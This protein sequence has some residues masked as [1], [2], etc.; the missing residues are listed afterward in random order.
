MY[1][2]T[3]THTHTHSHTH[4]R[5]GMVD[6][7]DK[8]MARLDETLESEVDQ[9]YAVYQM[10]SFE[11][12]KKIVLH[13]QELVL[14]SSSNPN[15]MAA[16]S[17]FIAD[18]YSQLVDSTRCALATLDSD[19]LTTTLHKSVLELGTDSKSLVQCAAGVQGNPYD[20][21]SKKALAEAARGVNLRVR[22]AYTVVGKELINIG[23]N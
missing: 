13:A 1:L 18:T 16:T 17:R 19:R 11:V 8:A 6:E 22:L 3:H 14:K 7:I 23:I 9:L 15:E 10:E 2:Y 4:T 12:C 21:P 5:K 20:Q